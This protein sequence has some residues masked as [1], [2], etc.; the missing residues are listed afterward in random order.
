MC[1]SVCVCACAYVSVCVERACLSSYTTVLKVCSIMLVWW[2]RRLALT[3]TFI[4]L[5][6]NV[7]RDSGECRDQSFSQRSHGN[8][9]RIDRAQHFDPSGMGECQAS[10][11]TRVSGD[12]QEV[13]QGNYSARMHLMGL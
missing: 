10:E 6:T 5:E 1:Q 12:P 3:N 8:N 11:D 9:I 4:A 13:G 2:V 7:T